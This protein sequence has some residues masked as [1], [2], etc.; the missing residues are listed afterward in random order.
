[1]IEKIGYTLLIIVAG[2]WLIAIIT[3]MVF[4][5]PV[6]IIGLI[7]ITGIGLLF[8]KVMQERLK[9]KEDDY[10]ADNVDK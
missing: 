8:I 3:G 1:M 4:A 9:N 6:G 10:Y 5:F 2:S 7:S